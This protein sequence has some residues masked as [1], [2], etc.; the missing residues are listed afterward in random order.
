MLVKLMKFYPL[1]IALVVMLDRIGFYAFNR[2][3][4]NRGFRFE[5]VLYIHGLYAIHKK[6]NLF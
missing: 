1:H 3:M 6:D 4:K 2:Y 5:Y